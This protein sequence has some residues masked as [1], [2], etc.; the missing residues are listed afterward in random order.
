MIGRS[1]ARWSLFQ[2]AAPLQAAAM[3]GAVA[4]WI[5]IA[6]KMLKNAQ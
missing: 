4:R 5:Q 6:T 3:E 2:V 1:V